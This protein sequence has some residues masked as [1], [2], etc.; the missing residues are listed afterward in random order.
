MLT[1]NYIMFVLIAA[2]MGAILGFCG[3]FARAHL[4]YTPERIFDGDGFGP[5]L[6]ND[7]LSSHN[8]TAEKHIVGAEWDDNGF[9]D[10]ESNRNLVYYMLSGFATP[11]IL[12]FIFWPQRFIVM[13]I[14]C[15]GLTGAGLHPP[16]C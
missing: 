15:Q 2:V 12:G 6:L 7:M 8:L 9:W 3:H 10:S 14:V 4:T 5:G 11:V 16:M 13:G 1:T